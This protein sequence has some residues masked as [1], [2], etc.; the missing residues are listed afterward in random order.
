MHYLVVLLSEAEE[1]GQDGSPEQFAAAGRSERVFIIWWCWLQAG[2]CV[3]AGWGM[4]SSN[5]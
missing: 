4:L 2:R 1:E 3:S 5:M